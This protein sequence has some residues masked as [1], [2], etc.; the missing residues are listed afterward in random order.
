[1]PKNI[2]LIVFYDYIF[3]PGGGTS[4]PRWNNPA[5]LGPK[6]DGFSS[7]RTNIVRCD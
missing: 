6:T 1:M 4:V 2:Y 7:P 5:D 3:Y